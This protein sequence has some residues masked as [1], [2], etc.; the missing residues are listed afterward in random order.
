MR[1]A[2]KSLGML[3]LHDKD[4]SVQTCYRNNPGSVIVRFEEMPSIFGTGNT[5]KRRLQ[6][7]LFPNLQEKLN[8][9]SFSR[10]EP[11]PA[12]EAEEAA[13]PDVI[14]R[15]DALDAASLVRK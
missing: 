6:C 9:R 10:E 15:A 14:S 13:L 8:Y 12:A 3:G 11:Q 7:C 2:F 4:R 5:V 1:R